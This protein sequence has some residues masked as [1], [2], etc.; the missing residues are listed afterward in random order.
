MRGSTALCGS[1]A[2]ED[3]LTG[4]P[5]EVLLRGILAASGIVGWP[6]ARLEDPW[7]Q[8]NVLHDLPSLSRTAVLLAALEARSIDYVARL[9]ANAALDRLAV[10]CMKR[11]RRAIGTPPA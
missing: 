11:P 7:R 3:R 5:G 9:R 2:R 4:E 6:G 8:A 1:S 10:P